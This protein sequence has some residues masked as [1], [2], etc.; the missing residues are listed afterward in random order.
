MDL[1]S[2]I[3]LAIQSNA[4]EAIRIVSLKTATLQVMTKLPLNKIPNR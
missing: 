2:P 1:L 4:V 3:F